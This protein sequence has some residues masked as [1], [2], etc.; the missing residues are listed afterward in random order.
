ME[1]WAF[2]AE[3]LIADAEAEKLEAEDE[4]RIDEID[5]RAEAC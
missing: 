3:W 5:D 4:P 2:L 1:R